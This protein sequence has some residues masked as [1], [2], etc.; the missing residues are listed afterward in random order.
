[1]GVLKGVRAKKT[2]EKKKTT[3]FQSL[4]VFCYVKN[5]NF[6]QE[7]SPLKWEF[8]IMDTG[9]IGKFPPLTPPSI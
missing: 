5:E 8:L 7:M 3:G 2:A 1:M 9:D 6:N 4:G